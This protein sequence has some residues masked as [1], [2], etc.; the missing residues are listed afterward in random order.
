MQTYYQ[1]VSSQGEQNRHNSS[2]YNLCT[3]EEAS[4][5]VGVENLHT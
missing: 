2:K 4:Y 3:T 5:K 1:K